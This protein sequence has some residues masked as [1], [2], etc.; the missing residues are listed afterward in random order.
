MAV[1]MVRECRPQSHPKAISTGKVAARGSAAHDGVEFADDV[2]EVAQGIRD[3]NA[4]V[5]F[6]VYPFAARTGRR[7]IMG[8]SGKA[9]C[10]EEAGR[11]WHL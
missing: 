10:F 3:V 6:K 5:A 7:G 8:M 4:N 2:E 9:W 11:R 1:E